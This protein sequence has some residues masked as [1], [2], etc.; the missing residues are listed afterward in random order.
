M[1]LFFAILTGKVT[2]AAA[3]FLGCWLLGGFAIQIIVGILD[4]KGGNQPGEIHFYIL[5]R[6]SCW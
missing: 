1:F 4:L 3:P 6:F 5:V 2:G